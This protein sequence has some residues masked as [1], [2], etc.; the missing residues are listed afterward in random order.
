LD[1]VVSGTDSQLG[2]DSSVTT[3]PTNEV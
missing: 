3:V 1:D 2:N